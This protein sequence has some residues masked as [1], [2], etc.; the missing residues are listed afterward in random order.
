VE[1][2][3]AV[4]SKLGYKIFQKNFFIAHAPTMLQHFFERKNG[5]I[6]F[7][8]FFKDFCKNKFSFACALKK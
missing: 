8:S 4:I 3:H 2:H 7:F 1:L 5:K 6:F